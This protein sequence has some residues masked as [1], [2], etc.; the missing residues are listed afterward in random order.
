[1]SNK[2]QY[3]DSIYVGDRKIF[4]T[5]YP[6]IVEKDYVLRIPK[7]KHPYIRKYT[8]SSYILIFFTYAFIG[9]FWEVARYFAVE[10]KLINRG[11][12]MGPWLPIYGVGGCLAIILFK[13][14][15][16]RPIFTF[17]ISMLLCSVME[18]VTG[19]AFEY[20]FDKRWWDYTG[21][22]L[23][24]Q[25]RVCLYGAVLFGAGCVISIYLAGPYLD[26]LYMK[27][28]TKIKHIICVILACIF[29]VDLVY[30]NFNPNTG[31][32][33]TEYAYFLLI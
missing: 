4:D 17:G 13:R 15:A 12:M 6:T 23:N 20:F 9:W 21:Y 2:V 10:G 18:Y 33:I 24:I 26:D 5:Q 27:I 14:F 7:L 31:E 25:G 30:S 32:G 3:I 8:I 19:W 22:F 29:I 16:K 28:P 11:F 1:M